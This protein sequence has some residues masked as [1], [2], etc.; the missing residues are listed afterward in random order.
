M[1]PGGARTRTGRR[2]SS[3]LCSAR[4]YRPFGPSIRPMPRSRTSMSGRRA[5]PTSRPAGCRR[6]PPRR[7]HSNESRRSSRDTRS[8]EADA[9]RLAPQQRAERAG[10]RLAAPAKK[11][12]EMTRL[13]RRSL[14]HGSLGLVATGTLARPYIANAAA[15]TAEVWWQ[16]GFVPEEDAGLKKIIADYEKASGNTIDLS[17]VPFAPL[18]QKIVAEGTSGIVPDLFPATPGEIIALYARDDKLIDVSDVVETQKSEYT[19]TALLSNY[20]YNHVEKKRSYYGV[21]TTQACL[22]NHI[23]RPLIEKAGYTLEDIPKTWDAF[24]DFFKDVQKKLRAQGERKVY[25]L[26]FQLNTTGN[27]SNALFN[28]FLIANGGQDIVTTDG[29]LHVDDPKVREAVVKALTYP[30]TAYKEGFVPPGAINWNDADDNNAFHAKQIVMDLDGSL[31]TEVAII[32]KEQDYN[33]IVTMGLPLSNDGKPVPS[34]QGSLCGLIP[35]GAKNVE[36]AKDFLKYLIQPAVLNVYL[37][38]GLG[39]NLPAMPAIVKDDPF[40]LDPKDPHRVAYTTQG[41]LGP[42]VPT[43][44]TSN[45]AY[46]QV[47]NE[48]VWAVAWAD[49][50]TGGIAPPAAAEKAFKRVEEI[51]A[52]YPIAQG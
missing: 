12:T 28:Y 9:A 40:W 34:Q 38:T 49:I 43:F 48:H 7:R 32:K 26:G 23:W 33:D 1:T 10:N 17:I 25:A 42:T 11:E 29:K 46:A 4:P 8:R 13:T 19:E 52:K 20:C 37:K 21:P 51:F 15:T 5:G 22:P 16:Q 50:M 31:S 41:L 2:T 39:R 24:Y 14:L 36:V 47:Q 44:W 3:R 35:K 45:P 27:D 18:R 6:R 30:T